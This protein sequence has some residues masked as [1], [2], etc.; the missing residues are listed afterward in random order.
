MLGK[1]EELLSLQ[2]KDPA[3]AR[4]KQAKVAADV[5][6]RWPNRRASDQRARGM[7]L[8]RPH[9]RL[10]SKP[11]WT[12]PANSGSWWNPRWDATI[13]RA[14]RSSLQC[15]RSDAAPDPPGSRRLSGPAP[16]RVDEG[17]WGWRNRAMAGVAMTARTAPSC[18]ARSDDGTR[19]ARS[20]AE[21]EHPVSAA[22][23][24]T[25]APSTAHRRGSLGVGRID[26]Y[27]RGAAA[28]S[29]SSTIRRYPTARASS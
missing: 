23:K 20:A 18:M 2:T 22:P 28:P 15:R 1:R 13:C 6:R 14:G 21:R 27:S 4:V 24:R 26:R 7:S 3:E 17:A 5:E 16:K 10:G 25:G 19:T 8:Q 11:M 29:V 12:S 9:T